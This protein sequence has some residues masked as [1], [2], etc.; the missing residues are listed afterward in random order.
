MNTPTTMINYDSDTAQ[1]L[2]KREPT[3][4]EKRGW[5]HRYYSGMPGGFVSYGG[6]GKGAVSKAKYEGGAT[7][8]CALYNTE[9]K[10]LEIDYDGNVSPALRARAEAQIGHANRRMNTTNRLK[11]KLEAKRAEWAEKAK[12][13]KVEDM[14]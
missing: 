3:K 6:N 10:Q 14:D 9:T 8:G 11:Q 7:V 4:A 12:D 2:V 1:A 13:P 5:E